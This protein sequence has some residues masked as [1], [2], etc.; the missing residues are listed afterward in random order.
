MPAHA[1]QLAAWRIAVSAVLLS[2]PELHEAVRWSEAPQE[3]LVPP[4]VLLWPLELVPIDPVAARAALAIAVVCG[5]LSLIGLCSRAACAGAG[6]AALY[7]LGI[8]QHAGTVTHDHHIVWFLA[9]LAVS[10]CGD[11][12]SVD[13]A[14]RAYRAASRGVQPRR[15]S[16][17]PAYALPLCFGWALVGVIFFFPGAWK[18]LSA[19]HAWIAG[20]ALLH[21]LH[22]KWTQMDWVPALRVDRSPWMC[23]AAG[24]ATIALELSFGVLVFVPRLRAWAVGA[25]LLFHALTAALMRVHFSSLW[26]CYVMFVD[27]DRV[28]RSVGHLLAP[29]GVQ[30]AHAL[31]G[32]PRH[33]RMAVL[34]RLDV[35]ALGRW[36]ATMDGATASVSRPAAPVHDPWPALLVGVPLLAANVV[37]G[38]L[39]IT[40]GWPLA[41]YPTFASTPGPMMPALVI[42]AVHADGRVVEVMHGPA[43]PGSRRQRDWGV[44]WSLV[45]AAGTPVDQERLFAYWRGLSSREP[46]RSAALDAE[47][48][49]FYRAW[50]LTDPDR[51]HQA[52][53]GRELL[54]EIVR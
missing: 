14:I 26:V 54:A 6:I 37:F 43:L 48:V 2:S 4:R 5:V 51:R 12:L 31:D 36:S 32:S 22:W 41:C 20:D 49:R 44:V 19:G 23:R 35:L 30:V 50:Q 27:W 7:L 28:L 13:A 52:P 33:R 16:P 34:R 46:A 8:A 42:E 29:D 21:H 11:A 17:S 47:R 45:G 3:L 1:V 39:G 38:A 24:I 18:L 53:V 9:L 10:P 15:P 40:D 25:A